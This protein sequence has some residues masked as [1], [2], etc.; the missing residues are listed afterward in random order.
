MKKPQA[1]DHEVELTRYSCVEE[2]DRRVQSD[3]IRVIGWL[4]ILAFLAFIAIATN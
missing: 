2:L 1:L 3:R 4:S